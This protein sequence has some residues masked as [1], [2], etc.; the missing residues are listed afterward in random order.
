MKTKILTMLFFIFWSSN[1]FALLEI[2]SDF[3]SSLLVGGS[4]DLLIRSNN[5]ILVGGEGFSFGANYLYDPLH[6]YVTDS[7]YGGAIKFG[8]QK[9]FQLSGGYFERKYKSLKGK[10]FYATA[11]LGWQWSEHFSVS[12]PII[13]K[14]ITNGGLDKRW[15]IDMIPYLGLRL[16]F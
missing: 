12:I 15:I 1:S 2:R 3:F 9:F 4:S 5:S 8:E 13:A 10:G 14:R 6:S 16:K 7:G 11:V